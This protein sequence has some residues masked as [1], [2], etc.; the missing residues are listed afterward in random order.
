MPTTVLRTPRSAQMPKRNGRER[1]DQQEGAAEQADLAVRQ[2]ELGLDLCG[3]GRQDVA[4]KVVEEIDADHDAEHVARVAA[5]H[6]GALCDQGDPR[7][8]GISEAAGRAAL[9]RGTGQ[10]SYAACTRIRGRRDFR[11]S[12]RWAA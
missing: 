2:M 1:V 10:A 12:A 5:G 9:S 6:R 4:V 7:V 3:D 8:S 11:P